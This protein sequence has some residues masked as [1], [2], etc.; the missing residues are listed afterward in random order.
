[1]ASNLSVFS[2]IEISSSSESPLTDVTVFIPM[3]QAL[4]EIGSVL[5][6]ANQSTLQEVLKYHVI[7]NNII[8]S[9]SISNTT[10]ATVQGGDLTFSVTD[11]GSVFVNNAKVVLPNILLY[12]GVAHV[13]DRCVAIS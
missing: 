10:A 6:A 8:F 9:P 12:E 3:D 11:D 2:G 4:E 13:I 7:Q 1:M 5:A